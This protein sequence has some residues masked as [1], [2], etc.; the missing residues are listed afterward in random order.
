MKAEV[1]KSSTSNSLVLSL[2]LKGCEPGRSERSTQQTGDSCTLKQILRNQELSCQAVPK[3]CS[4]SMP[5]QC[6]ETE[7]CSQTAD[8][9]GECLCRPGMIRQS[10]G[11]CSLDTTTSTTTLSPDL[12]TPIINST[13][14]TPDVVK[15]DC[16]LL[17]IYR[18]NRNSY[19]KFNIQIIIQLVPWL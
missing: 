12:T 15:K 9:T 3:Q 18:F 5:F 2:M 8:E 16:M 13:T 4:I 10:N 1:K 6:A 14:E 17:L 7:T 19:P 11:T